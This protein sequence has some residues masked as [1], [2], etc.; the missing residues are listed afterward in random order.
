V[1]PIAFAIFPTQARASSDGLLL[2]GAI[3]IYKMPK[4]S[5]DDLIMCYYRTKKKPTTPLNKKSNMQHEKNKKYGTRLASDN[6]YC[7]ILPRVNE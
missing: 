4:L 2:R 6:R 1:V 7:T 3:Y 5:K